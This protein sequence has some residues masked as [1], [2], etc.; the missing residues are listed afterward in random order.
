MSTPLTEA[1]RAA[2]V[3]DEG[4]LEV[5][6]G[7]QIAYRIFGTGERVL[8]VLHGGPGVSSRYLDRLAEVVSDDVRLVLYDQLGGGDSD[9]PDDPSL[10]QVPRFIEEVET[11][12]ST[13]DLGTVTLFGQS[14]GG[15][16]ALAYS[17]DH[18]EQVNALVLSNTYANGKSYL[19][20]IA[21]HRMNLGAD[22]HALMMKRELEGDLEADDY[23]DAVLELYSRRP[24]A[25]GP[26]RT[27]R[28]PG[29]N[30]PISP[31]ASSRTP[32]RPMPSGARTSSGAPGRRRTSTSHI[33]WERSACPPSSSAAGTTSCRPSAAAVPWLTA[34]P[35]TS[36]SS[37]AIRAIS[38]FSRRR[39][40]CTWR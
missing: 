31:G 28:R 17:L 29:A 15:M 3:S 13:L 1:G 16:L 34:S 37:S 40:T 20:D 23:K 26:P 38:P 32:G 10:W 12:R 35:T 27:G 24:V 14:W 30:S 4:R 7:Y 9:R 11:V 6:N 21:Q 19:L 22:V 36:T 5:E 2:P 8:L 39:A 18:P 33:A 25:L